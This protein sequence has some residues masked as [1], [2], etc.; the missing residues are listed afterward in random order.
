VALF[1]V[2]GKLKARCGDSS[3]RK[4]STS[5]VWILR[6]SAGPDGLW[7]IFIAGH[8]F[9]SIGCCVHFGSLRALLASIANACNDG[10]NGNW[11]YAEAVDA[12][13]ILPIR[14]I[15]VEMRWVG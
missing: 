8:A 5:R 7:T 12:V 13:N 15:N 3:Q 1:R 9:R 2:F 14:A 10:F 11:T 6:W 4:Q